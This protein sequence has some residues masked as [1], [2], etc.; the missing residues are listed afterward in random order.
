MTLDE[1]PDGPEPSPQ[2][3]CWTLMFVGVQGNTEDSKEHSLKG[4]ET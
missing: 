4:K 3:P 2:F 1:V